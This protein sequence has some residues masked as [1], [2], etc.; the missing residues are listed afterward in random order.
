MLSIHF[1]TISVNL[2]SLPSIHGGIS[3]NLGLGGSTRKNGTLAWS[4]TQAMVIYVHVYTAIFKC[5]NVQAVKYKDRNMCSGTSVIAVTLSFLK[6][7]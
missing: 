4:S 7:L 2:I 3:A 6:S 1:L 5:T